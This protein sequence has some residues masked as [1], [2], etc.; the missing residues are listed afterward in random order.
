VSRPAY[1]RV[2]FVNTQ[3]PPQISKNGE[4]WVMKLR[5][6]SYNYQFALE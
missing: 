1:D 4:Q 3:D 5:Q 6:I 2:S